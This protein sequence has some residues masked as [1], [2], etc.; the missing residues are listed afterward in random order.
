M[1]SIPQITEKMNYL[2]SNEQKRQLEDVGRVEKISV[3]VSGPPENVTL[4]MNNEIS[5][6]SDC[7]KRKFRIETIVVQSTE[8][9]LVINNS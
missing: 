8:M 9:A 7:C 6:P 3:D 1:A 4:V 2:F 5:T